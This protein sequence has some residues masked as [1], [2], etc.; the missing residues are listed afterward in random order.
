MLGRDEV[1]ETLVPTIWFTRVD[2][3]TLGRP[4]TATNPERTGPS[5]T[6]VVGVTS[7]A[8]AII[9]SNGTSRPERL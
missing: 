4:T 3:P 5:A 6:L 1:M 8:V 7:V 2:L 9:A